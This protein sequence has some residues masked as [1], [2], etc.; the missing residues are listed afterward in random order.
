MGC[1]ENLM[2][3]PSDRSPLPGGPQERP[4]FPQVG[5]GRW[6][7][8]SEGS[9]SRLPRRPGQTPAPGAPPA[10]R[11]GAGPA[12]AVPAAPQAPMLV[13]PGQSPARRFPEPSGSH[14]SQSVRGGADPPPAVAHPGAG[15]RCGPDLLV[16][17][18]SR[19]GAPAA[20]GSSFPASGRHPTPELLESFEISP[21]PPT[22]TLQMEKLRPRVWQRLGQGHPA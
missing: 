11:G 19:A 16:G 7:R 5:L 15:G 1:R 3:S 21:A 8:R 10:G 22:P 2:W 17:W 6:S 14:L 13:N 4:R 20:P 18:G 12:H 9:A